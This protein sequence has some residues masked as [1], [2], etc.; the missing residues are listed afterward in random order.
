MS[1]VKIIFLTS[2]EVL[3]CQHPDYLF[4]RTGLAKVALQNGDLERAQALLEPLYERRKF[5]FSE[6]DA[7]CA[8]QIDLL[9]LQNDRSSA[10]TW[11]DM[12][13]DCNPQNPKLD[14]YCKLLKC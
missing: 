11:F 12:W 3:Y 7:L 6:F 4:A 10:K 1:F 9:L 13:E 2:I 5:H 8:T 14:F